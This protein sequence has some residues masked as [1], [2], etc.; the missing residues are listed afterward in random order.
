MSMKKGLIS[1]R[2]QE[3]PSNGPHVRYLLMT[4]TTSFLLAVGV[5]IIFFMIGKEFYNL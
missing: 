4:I 3:F 5:L 2:R 1:W